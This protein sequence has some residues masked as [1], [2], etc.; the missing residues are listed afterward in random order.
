MARAKSRFGVWATLVGSLAC[1][2][3]LLLAIAPEP[4]RPELPSP[5]MA[6]APAQSDLTAI[7]A[8]DIQPGRWKYIYVHHSKTP[9]GDARTLG[10]PTS[11]LPGH[12]LVGNGNGLA[13]GQIQIGWRWE[14][15]KSAMPPAGVASID[16]ACIRITLVGDFDAASPSATQLARTRQL[17][18]ALQATARISDDGVLLF[19]AAGQPAGAG[20][21]TRDALL[22]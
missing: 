4:M 11:G 20:K 17:I 14:S 10:S 1:T 3:A 7:V 8:K 6:A 2:S 15:Q 18:Q 9:A 12:F 22:R 21:L 5:L 16:P 13:D 19:S